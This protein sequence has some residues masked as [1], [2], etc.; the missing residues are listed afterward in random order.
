M[1][2]IIQKKKEYIANDLGHTEAI[3]Q[4]SPD[5]FRSPL[6]T[7]DEIETIK[8]RTD[9]NKFEVSGCKAI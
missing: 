4:E 2:T 5:G 7:E 3:D 6:P 9:F 8:A 1:A